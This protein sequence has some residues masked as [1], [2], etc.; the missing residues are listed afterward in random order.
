MAI[1][2]KN[3]RFIACVRELLTVLQGRVL[4]AVAL[5]VAIMVTEGLGIFLLIPL[6]S[7]AG[8]GQDAPTGLL[9]TAIDGLAAAGIGLEPRSVLLAFFVATATRAMFAYWQSVNVARLC[10]EFLD[11]LRMRL[12]RGF[13]NARYEYMTQVRSSDIVHALSEEVGRVRGVVYQTVQL[14][15]HAVVTGLLIGMAFLVSWQATLVALLAGASLFFML[16]GR[17]SRSHQIGEAI[18]EHGA[19]LV[20]A[21]SEHLAG[22]KVA[23]SHHA[24]AIHEEAFREFSESIAV[25][26]VD[27]ARSYADV[28]MR[29]H[30]AAA[31]LACAVVYVAL[32]WLRIPSGELLLLVVLFARLVPRFRSA[33]YG[34]QELLN[35][36]PA[37]GRIAE[38]SAAAEAAAGGARVSGEGLEPGA[39]EFEGVTFRYPPEGRGGVTN[40]SFRVQPGEAMGIIGPSGAGKSTI[41]DLMTGLLVPREGRVRVAGRMAY[42]CQDSFLFHDTIRTNLA[43]A[44]PG[45]TDDDIWRALETVRASDFVRRLPDGLSSRVGDRGVRL[46]G[47][48]RQRLAI[49]RAILMNPDILIMD[50]GT[51]GVDLAIEKE[52]HQNLL[53][54]KGTLTVVLISHREMPAWV[55][56]ILQVAA[57]FSD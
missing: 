53:C 28:S 10:E 13:M 51:S 34:I 30:I 54:L 20:G 16:W 24:E 46:S 35:S 15:G 12:Y 7:M 26:G 39:I 1:A 14:T 3:K 25:A 6:L 31:A 40:V 57:R 52:I 47:G 19:R 49:A 11:H 8:F 38:L 36:L 21:A 55:D 50:E 18:T 17:A 42:V 43:W 22:I 27:A 33:Q 5:L 32:A 41:A 2:T 56:R 23:K 44:R 9:R 37:Y 29:F 45:A 48:E 4:V